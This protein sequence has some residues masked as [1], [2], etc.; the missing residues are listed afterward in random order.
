MAFLQLFCV[1]FESFRKAAFLLRPAEK[2]YF[3][4][5]SCR[6]AVLLCV[7]CAAAGYLIFSVSESYVF[8]S[9]SC[10][11]AAYIVLFNKKIKHAAPESCRKA[12]YYFNLSQIHLKHKVAA[13]LQLLKAAYLTHLKLRLFCFARMDYV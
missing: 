2:L 9:E 11:K 3:F 5:N 10:R 6:K 13:F 7:S 12:E 8:K 4:S 1:F